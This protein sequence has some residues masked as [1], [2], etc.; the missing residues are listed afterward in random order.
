MAF[1]LRQTLRPIILG[2]VDHRRNPPNPCAS[3]CQ[4]KLFTLPFEG[5]LQTISFEN[6]RGLHG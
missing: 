1:A 3:S 4:S 6:G 5:D 2:I